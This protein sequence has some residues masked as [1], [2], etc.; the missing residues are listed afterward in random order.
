MHT[1]KEITENTVA[2]QVG[3]KKLLNKWRIRSKILKKNIP[4]IFWSNRK[5]KTTYV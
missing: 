3:T 2:Y 1:R 4:T 5:K